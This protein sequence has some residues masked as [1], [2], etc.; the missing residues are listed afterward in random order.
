MA[1][2]FLISDTHFGHKGVTQFINDDGTPLR[3]WDTT[4]EMDEALVQNWNSVVKDK[5]RVYHLGDV[6]INRRAL[7][8]LSRLKGRLVLI[9]GNHD[10]F[11]LKDYLPYFDDI[12]GSHKLDSFILTHI[13]IHPESL[14]R[15]ADGNIH[16]HLH[17]RQVMKSKHHPDERYINV[18]VEQINYTPIAFEEIRKRVKPKEK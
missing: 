11:K 1:N 12:R 2:T 6:V 3:P 7:T 14:A 9:K 10:I 5:D 15:W 16:G 18:S 4:E 13:P 17:S 8:T